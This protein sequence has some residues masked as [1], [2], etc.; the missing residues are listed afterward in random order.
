M[1]YI[2]KLCT[3]KF[4]LAEILLIFPHLLGVIIYNFCVDS[5]YPELIQ[6]K[7]TFSGND[8]EANIR[9]HQET[10]RREN[11]RTPSNGN[12]MAQK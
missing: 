5:A 4:D 8:Q 2:K 12:K 9:S 10:Q 6:S 7:E 11:S 3:F 1:T